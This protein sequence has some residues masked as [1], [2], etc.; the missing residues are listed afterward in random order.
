MEELVLGMLK[1]GPAHGYA[2][3]ER[4]RAELGPA[5]R[6]GTSQLYASLRRLEEGASSA[7][8]RRRP[9]EARPGSSTP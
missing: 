5:W 4:I 9:P 7:G 8:S 1:L 3:R 6:V 2:L